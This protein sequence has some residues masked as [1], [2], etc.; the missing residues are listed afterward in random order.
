MHDVMA[1]FTKYYKKHGKAWNP[2]LEDKGSNKEN[3]DTNNN[4]QKF[5]MQCGNKFP[6]LDRDWKYCKPCVA[7]HKEKNMSNC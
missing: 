5:C 2:N 4:R 1:D 6:Q 7:K 3:M